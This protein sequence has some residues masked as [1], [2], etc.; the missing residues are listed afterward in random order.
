MMQACRVVDKEPRD[1]VSL[2]PLAVQQ[3]EA[4]AEEAGETQDEESW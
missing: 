1:F 3:A 4:A 2:L